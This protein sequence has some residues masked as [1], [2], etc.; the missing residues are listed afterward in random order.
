MGSILLHPY[1]AT[2]TDNPAL[3]KAALVS[4]AGM[5]I[6]EGPEVHTSN[7]T[8]TYGHVHTGS[9]LKRLLN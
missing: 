9:H 3:G 4:F 7:E 5:L 8:H 6:E 2:G 1:W